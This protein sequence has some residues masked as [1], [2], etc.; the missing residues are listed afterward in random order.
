[1]NNLEEIKKQLAELTAQVNELSETKSDDGMYHFTEEEMIKF[2]ERLHEGFEESL[3]YNLS[4][5]SFDTDSVSLSL[6]GNEIEIEIDSDDIKDTIISELD[7]DLDEDSIK[8]TITD[9]YKYIK[10]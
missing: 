7:F 10:K 9:I 2:V 5:I 8:D 1:M 6:N 3:E 4:G